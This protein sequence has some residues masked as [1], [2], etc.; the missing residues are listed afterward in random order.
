MKL[1]ELQIGDIITRWISVNGEMQKFM[2]LVVVGVTD[3]LVMA[4]VSPEFP[5]HW[6]FD[7][8]E[9][10]EVDHELGWGPQYGVSGT[11][12]AFEKPDNHPR[13]KSA[14]QVLHQKMQH[15]NKGNVQ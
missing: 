1:S 3:K 9:G 2:D 11:V 8:T 6:T 13:L 14:A 10:V 4:S 15:T 12:I 7:K 5:D